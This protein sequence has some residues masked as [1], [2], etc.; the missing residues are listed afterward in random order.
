MERFLAFLLCA[1]SVGSDPPGLVDGGLRDGTVDASGCGGDFACDD[2]IAC[3]IDRCGE[4]ACTTTP[5]IDCCE[6]GTVCAVDLGCIT[7]P[8]PC[9]GDDDCL[10]SIRCTLDFCG[11]DGTCAHRPQ[12]GLCDSGEVCLPAVGCIP[13]P[14]TTCTTAADCEVGAYCV[15]R[16][17]C[18]P[19]FGCQFVALRDC[20]DMDE[21]TVDSCSEEA[22]G[23]VHDPRDDDAD[24][25]VASACGGDDCNDADPMVSPSDPELCNTRDDDCD[26]TTDETCCEP[27]LPCTTSCGTAGTTTCDPEGCAPPAETCNGLDDDCD[28]LAD[29]SFD[30]VRDRSESCMTACDSTGM[31]TCNTSCEWDACVAPAESCNAE[32]DD[33]DGMRDEGFACIAGTSATCRTMCGSMGSRDCLPDC[34]YDA[35]SPPSESCNGEDDDCDGACDDGFTC[36]E[37]STRDCTAFGFFAGTAVCRAGCGSWNTTPCTNC[38]NGTRNTGEACDGVDLGGEDCTSIGM[39]FGS[40]TL[41]CAAGCAFDTSS[42]SRCRNGVIDA[43]EDCDGTALGGA[44]CTTVPG[45]FTGGTL[46]CSSA[47]RYDTA[48]CIAWDPSGDYAT[49]PAPTYT[50]AFGLVNFSIGLF[51]FSDSGTILVVNGAPCVMSGV[52]PRATRMF[53]VQCTIPGSCPE[54][55]RLTGMFTSDDRWT[56]T[57][58]ANFGP[59]SCFGCT[60]QMWS[61]TGMR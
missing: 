22:M 6:M 14:P 11:S 1:C 12:D 37:G 60:N 10:D 34:S 39:G 43:G 24:G 41:R 5:C 3:T 40:G 32:D 25:H 44:D 56:G 21:C 59:G 2:R 46:R 58:R 55:Y 38:G 26:G 23:C 61:V 13:E 52:S 45:G 30:C 19:E 20:D 28:G 31:R 49:T 48:M 57:F 4:G 42:C 36:C 51:E 8:K 50:C 17:S 35:C 53:D 15:G 9:D 18:D 7:A 54:N 16:W 47:C 27:G 29:Q 33:C